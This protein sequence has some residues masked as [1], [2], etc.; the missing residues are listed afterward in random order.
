MD[1]HPQDSDV[2]V[3]GA[4]DTDKQEASAVK[5]NKHFQWLLLKTNI[6]AEQKISQQRDT[7]LLREVQGDLGACSHQ[8]SGQLQNVL[9]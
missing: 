3:A 8:S 1:E 9:C 6:M 4:P 5:V 7:N 2:P